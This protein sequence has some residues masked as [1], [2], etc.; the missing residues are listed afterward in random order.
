MNPEAQVV[1]DTICL[2][3]PHELTDNDI[4]FLRARRSYLT[5]EQLNRYA[6]VLSLPKELNTYQKKESSVDDDQELSGL[7]DRL[8]SEMTIEQLRIVGK[9]L[10]IRGVQLYKDVE[11]LRLIIGETIQQQ[12]NT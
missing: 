7:D 11:K 10:G 4:G 2:K 12:E 5:D 3:E 9:H 6:D 1:F 8:I